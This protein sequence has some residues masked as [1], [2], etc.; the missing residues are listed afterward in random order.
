MFKLTSIVAL[1]AV[2]GMIGGWVTPA[3]GA[4]VSEKLVPAQGAWLGAWSAE[5]GAAQLEPAMLEHEARIGRRLDIVHNF[6]PVGNL[7]LNTQEVK[8]VQSGR[9]LFVN[10][11]PASK[12]SDAG[13]GNATVNATIAKVA[14][15]FASVKPKRVMLTIFHEPENDMN[16]TAGSGMTPAD[17]RAMWH[18]V[19]RIF[20]EQGADN[21]VYAWNV[22]GWKGWY[23]DMA[24]LWPG[25]EYVDWIMWD[26]Y[27]HGKSWRETIDPFYDWMTDNST[28]EHN[29]LSKAWGLGEWGVTSNAAYERQFYLDIKADLRRYP[30]MKAYVIF[31]TKKG[32]YDWRTNSTPE[33]QA[34]YNQLANDSFFQQALPVESRVAAWVVYE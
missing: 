9:I 25:N 22:M 1:G 23:N 14:K 2:A 18:N 26:S 20:D 11:K 4:E 7:P 29:Y 10:W 31:D 13:G 15:S 24:S 34:A 6:H 19:R 16:K 27:S 21:V 33:E 5:H 32:E 3:G 8:V 12:W 17:Y 30:R 28:P